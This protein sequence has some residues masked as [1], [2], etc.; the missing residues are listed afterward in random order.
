MSPF[1]VLEIP[2]LML[3]LLIIIDAYSCLIIGV[4]LI[5]VS[6]ANVDDAVQVSQWL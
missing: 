5:Y 1:G 6:K 4:P 2:M 3:K